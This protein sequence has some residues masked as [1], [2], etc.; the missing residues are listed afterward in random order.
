M[1]NSNLKTPFFMLLKKQTD[2]NDDEKIV[3]YVLENYEVDFYTYRSSELLKMMEQQNP[4]F[5]LPQKKIQNI[6]FDFMMDLINN[7]REIDFD[8]Y[9]RAFKDKAGDKFD[10]Y[11]LRF[12]EVTVANGMKDTV[13]FLLDQRVNVNLRSKEAK[14]SKPAAFI[15][16]SNGYFG[17][18]E[19]LVKRPELKFSYNTDS[20]K[21]T[22]LHEVC[23][24]FAMRSKENKNVNYQKCFD[25]IIKDQRCE[26]NAE[27]DIG[28]SPLH[29]TVI[30][31]FKKK[32]DDYYLK[33]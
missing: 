3:E 22:L 15:A 29:Y 17:I 12:L 24:N 25:L 1:P 13:E 18:L 26:I 5:K 19:L 7:R 21:F 6:S 4:Q 32:I 23:Q 16:C 11:C 9:F 10:D 30:N 31:F 33:I 27:D 8:I 14:Y 20:Q 2:I 28:C